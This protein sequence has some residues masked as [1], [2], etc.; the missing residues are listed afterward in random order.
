[1]SVTD[2]TDR[3][4]YSSEDEPGVP[5]QSFPALSDVY[6]ARL[7]EWFDLDS[8][9]LNAPNELDRARAI[10][11]SVHGRWTHSN[12]DE[13]SQNDPITI[14]REAAKGKRFRCVQF[15]ITLAGALTAFGII[16]RVVS[17]MSQDVETRESGASHVVSEAWLP[18][19]NKWIMLDAQENAVVFDG[20]VPL[21]CTEIAA[22]PLD[23]RLA[24]EIPGLPPGVD[25][26]LYLGP[27]GFGPNF[28]Y[29]QTRLH[30]RRIDG[31][32]VSNEGERPSILLCPVG[33]AEP[34]VFQRGSP[35]TNVVYTRSAA[36]FYRPPA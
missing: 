8:R 1:V 34:R 20:S 11:A 15:G 36:A 10:C 32:E 14:L 23:E 3:P 35:F 27:E 19:L 5:V 29:F 33:A 4:E 13:P 6:F 17:M 9:N 18:S 12:D 26:R 7:R 31:S 2:P 25:P 16:A 30:Q 22:H 24:V 21:N 28:Y